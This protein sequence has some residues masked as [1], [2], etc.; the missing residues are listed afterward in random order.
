MPRRQYRVAL[1]ILAAAALTFAGCPKRAA[2]APSAPVTLVAQRIVSTDNSAE[3]IAPAPAARTEVEVI[4]LAQADSSDK[5]ED[6]TFNDLKFD[7]KPSSRYDE[8]LLTPRIKG[9]EG[10]RIRVPG[11]MLPTFQEK[12]IKEFIL[13]MNTEC[14][15]GSAKDPVWC[16][17]RVTMDEDETARYSTRAVKVEGVLGLEVLEGENYDI[18][19]YTLDEAK[20]VK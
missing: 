15:Y 10:K 5:P 18:S 17:I 8:A 16:N 13:L 7:I 20:V 19:L 14:K 1:P 4:Q 12:N 6:I 9:L 3:P 11:I 2:E